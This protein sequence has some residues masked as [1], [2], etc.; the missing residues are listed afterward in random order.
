MRTLTDI[1]RALRIPVLLLTA[2]ALVSLVGC[3]GATD[4]PFGS[5]IAIEPYGSA[6]YSGPTTTFFKDTT[7]K[8]QTYRVTVLDADGQPMDGIDVNFLGQFTNGQSILFSSSSGTAP[9][10]LHATDTAKNGILFFDITAPFYAQG[11]Q[12]NPPLNQKALVG[13]QPGVLVADTYFYQITSVDFGGECPPAAPI[14]VVI[15]G[16]TT[17]G[18]VDLSWAKVAGATDYNVYGANSAAPTTFELLFTVICPPTGCS[19]PVT[20]TDFGNT[21]ATKAGKPIPPTTNTTGLSL[22]DI[23]GTMQATSG[24]ALA[25]QS[26]NF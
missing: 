26:I 18:S 25:T 12:L 15:S 8:T 14:S 21:W 2:L 20:I 5:T 19:D 17:T 6:V 4:A 13:T 16:A 1:G 7:T 9:I 10:T 23:L 11:T 3:K 22:N 24:S